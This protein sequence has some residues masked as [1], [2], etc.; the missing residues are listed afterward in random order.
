MRGKDARRTT[1]KSATGNIAALKKAVSHM[2]SRT[3]TLVFSANAGLLLIIVQEART[4]SA[5]GAASVAA[6]RSRA[7]L[8]RRESQAR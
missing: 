3:R 5:T 7:R 8:G 6:S 2:L 1:G 4:P